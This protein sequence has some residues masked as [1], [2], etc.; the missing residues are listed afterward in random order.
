MKLVKIN[1][2]S[3][4]ND[5]S[6]SAGRALGLLMSKDKAFG[7]VPFEC[8]SKC[9]DALVRSVINYGAAIWGSSNFSSISAVQNRACRFFLGLG[10]YAPN[11]AVQG[12]MGLMLP[13]HRQWICVIK[14]FCRMINMEGTLLSKRIFTWSLT[15]SSSICRTLPYGVRK[16]LIRIDMEYVLQA[17]EVNTIGLFCLTLTLTLYFYCTKSGK[18][19]CSRPRLLQAKDV[20]VTN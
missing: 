15:Q 1:T 10:K 12:D 7:G 19:N 18:R 2:C 9:Y 14:Q 4:D 16:F 17:Y 11:P 20:E 6:Q 13:E 8:Y 5:V 3:T